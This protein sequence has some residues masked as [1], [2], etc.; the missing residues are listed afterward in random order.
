MSNKYFQVVK[1]VKKGVFLK[2]GEGAKVSKCFAPI[3]LLPETK[4]IQEEDAEIH[5]LYPVGKNV[6]QIR[7]GRNDLFRRFYIGAADK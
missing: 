1:T 6:E 2:I 5:A 4:K 7:L 3:G